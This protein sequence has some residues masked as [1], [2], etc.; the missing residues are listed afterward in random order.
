MDKQNWEA[1]EVL[2]EEGANPKATTFTGANAVHILIGHGSPFKIAESWPWVV[3]LVKR[4]GLDPNARIRDGELSGMTAIH[5]ASLIA[6]EGYYF[7]GGT[8]YDV[9]PILAEKLLNMGAKANAPLRP[10]L[11]E[12]GKEVP[13]SQL[14][15]SELED[16]LEG[17][18]VALAVGHPGVLRKLRD[19]AKESVH[20]IHLVPEIW[21]KERP[22]TRGIFL[23]VHLRK[24]EREARR[25]LGALVGKGR[26]PEERIESEEVLAWY[27]ELLE[28]DWAPVVGKVK[29]ELG[30]GYDTL[31]KALGYLES[32][33]VLL[34]G[35]W[36]LYEEPGGFGLT[37][38]EEDRAGLWSFISGVIPLVE[39]LRKRREKIGQTMGAA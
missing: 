11:E 4:V 25:L 26:P 24:A 34:G 22:K 31:K 14:T 8:P 21:A 2:L 28:L 6:S 35:I 36:E 17:S 3:K 12:E 7:Y 32:M 23:P 10:V 18:P 39:K 38:S 37:L 27:G 9:Y 1:A 19:G 30:E 16:S 29:E 33:P 13:L 5:L 15:L 20:E